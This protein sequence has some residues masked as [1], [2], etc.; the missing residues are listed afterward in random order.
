M[1]EQI[2]LKTNHNVRVVNLANGQ[3]VLCLFGDI[4]DGDQDNKVIGY[5][6]LYPFA[7]SLGVENED[8]TIPIEYKRWCP[9]SPQEEH[10]LSGEHIVSVVFPDNGILD[11]YANKLREL[12]VPDENI[13]PPEVTDGSEGKPAE[14]SE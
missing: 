13:F 8:G 7:L 3:N 14:A 10:R 4:R 11:N 6:M 12:G 1:T 2:E 9:Y 5:R